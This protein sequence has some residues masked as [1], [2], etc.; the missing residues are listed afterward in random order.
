MGV[1]RSCPVS[2]AIIYCRISR[3]IEGQEMGIQRQEAAC[4]ELCE[5][6]RLTV[7]GVE[8][9]NDASGYSGKKRKGWDRVA[10]AI[11]RGG[12]THLVGWAPDRFTRHPKELES[13]IDLLE[14]AKVKVRTA[15]AGEYDLTTPG[16]RLTARVVGAVARG[17]SEQKSARLCLKAIQTAKAGKVSG[18]GT[19]C[20]GFQKDRISHHPEEAEAIR[21]AVDEIAAGASLRSVCRRMPVP[22]VKAIEWTAPSLRRTLLS[23]RI[24]GL[25]E[26]HGEIVG[27][28]QWA[29]IVGRTEWET[30]RA[31]LTAPARKKW[32][33][34]QKYLL[35]G[36]VIVDRHGQ[37]MFARPTDKGRRMY[38]TLASPE[39]GSGTA[40]DAQ[41]TDALIWEMCRDL[42]S[43]R[44]ERMTQPTVQPIENIE[45]LEAELLDMALLKSAG[46]ISLM[47]W[48]IVRQPIQ[49]R[50]DATRAALA[51]VRPPLDLQSVLAH[52][53]TL[54][55]NRRRHVVS[56]LFSTVVINVG[57]R[58]LNR[59]DPRRVV[60]SIRHGRVG[61]PQMY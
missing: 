31:V 17:E 51:T 44:V 47:E 26:H 53:E 57:I 12:V 37:P 2:H 40:I 21:W 45:A 43:D 8:A 52:W 15:T 49:D 59:F 38:I 9:D 58:G 16:G 11:K 48:T 50:L 28:A 46:T 14:A 20:L 19:R 7:R 24:A 22:P 56:E 3:D 18:G 27:P 39:F 32:R 35:S 36:G 5:R 55:I 61:V 4:R 25:R 60:P 34:T 54:D 30:C 10:E 29:P 1:L 33:P 41:K 23:P 42:I 13:L 6:E